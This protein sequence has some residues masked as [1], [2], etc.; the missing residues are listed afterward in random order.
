MTAATAP[1]FWELPQAHPTGWDTCS[2]G[3]VPGSKPPSQRPGPGRLPTQVTSLRHM[4]GLQGAGWGEGRQ[5]TSQV[6]DCKFLG[7]A[8][9]P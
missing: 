8:L 3:S 4:L 2:H 5:D 1:T 9:H 7:P 6:T